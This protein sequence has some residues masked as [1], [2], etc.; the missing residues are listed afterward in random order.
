MGDGKKTESMISEGK[1]VLDLRTAGELGRKFKN[2]LDQ[3]EPTVR[4]EYNKFIGELIHLNQLTGLDLLLKVTCRNNLTSGILDI[5]CK[6]SLVESLIELGSLPR[7]IL[8]DYTEDK[9]LVRN[10]LEKHSYSDVR[11][12]SSMKRP[13][14]PR[15][16]FLNILKSVFGAVNSYVW[17]R[18]YN[19]KRVPTEPIKYIDTFLF[20]NSISSSGAVVDRY[21]T[22]HENYLSENEISKEWLAPTLVGIKYPLEYARIFRL[23]KNSDRKILIQEAWLGVLDY[24]AAFVKSFVIP[25]SITQIPFF[26]GIDVSPLIKR[27]NGRDVASPLLMRAIH[28]YL[29]VGKLSEENV[30]IELAID[31][32]E[33]QTYD[34]A[35]NLGFKRSFPDVPVRGYQGFVAMKQHASLYPTDYEYTA[36]T[37]PDSYHV[38]GESNRAAVRDSC[39]GM[40]VSLA[41]AFRFSHIFDIQDKR[42][43]ERRIV[44]VAL[45]IMIDECRSIVE[46]CI[47]VSARLSSHIKFVVKHHPG[48]TTEKFSKL[49]PSYLNDALEKTDASVKDLLEI[50]SVVISSGSS[51]CLE[52]ISVGIP[53]AINGM[54]GG[55]TLNPIPENISDELWCIYYSNDQLHEFVSNVVC[56][57]RQSH[58][59]AGIFQPV[60]REGTEAL[61]CL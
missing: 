43:E 7:L 36:G 48:I 54:K 40:P 11:V 10:M 49:V 22:G 47:D 56:F 60:T 29:F 38:I 35:L 41:P 23:I 42:S 19:V 26:R 44:F 14:I 61:F 53:V 34:R 58:N 31:W 57:E 59:A 46:S 3:I 8:V 28:R 6:I 4:G 21:Y 18:I 13:G 25:R 52:A 39:E 27:E 20:V 9:K 2:Q 24:F 5:F 32:S 17:S 37:L 15:T 16:V 45:P 55:V 30:E 12:E 51:V 50:S 33:N 1:D